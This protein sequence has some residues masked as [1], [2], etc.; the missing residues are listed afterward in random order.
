MF[1]EILNLP[2][3][4]LP[5]YAEFI[6]PIPTAFGAKL[7]WYEDAPPYIAEYCVKS[8][9]DVDRLV[10]AGIPDPHQEGVTS[11]IIRRLRYFVKN[12]PRDL[13]ESHG[14]ID[15]NVYPG[16]LIEGAALTMGYDKFFNLE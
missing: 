2:M 6:G 3:G 4:I 10:E 15:G 11:E 14:Y 1:P 13:R 8:P 16:A 9:E 12:F 7:G 5:E